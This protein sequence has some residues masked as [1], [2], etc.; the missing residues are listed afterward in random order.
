MEVIRARVEHIPDM[1]ALIDAFA[2]R[3]MMLPRSLNAMYQNVR[4]FYVCFD[5]ELLVGC[6]A[7]H[8]VWANLAE[9]KSLA[10][11]ESVQGKGVGRLLVDAALADARNLHLPR[12]FCLTYSPEFFRKMGFQEI[13][14][15]ELPHS[16]WAECVNCVKFPDCDEIAMARGV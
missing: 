12:V 9:V 10:V 15:A 3:N 4:D 1:K 2:Q 8:V 11:H 6:V 14:K 5:G 7:L 16:V 13:D